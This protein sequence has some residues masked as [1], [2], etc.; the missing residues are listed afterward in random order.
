M[1]WDALCWPTWEGPPGTELSRL[2]LE[3][4][5]A[6]LRQQSQAARLT[7][8]AEGDRSELGVEVLWATH[9]DFQVAYS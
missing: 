9:G 2:L 3:A 7:E 5:R 6:A 4:P 8:R 1:G